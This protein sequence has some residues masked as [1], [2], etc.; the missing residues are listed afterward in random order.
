VRVR[1]SHRLGEEI[2]SMGLCREGWI[3]KD[4]DSISWIGGE[5][6]P[7]RDHTSQGE[8]RAEAAAGGFQSIEAT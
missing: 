5:G 3:S 7:Y 8:E 1:R 6:I 4:H 2:S